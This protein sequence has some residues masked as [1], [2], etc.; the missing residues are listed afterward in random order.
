MAVQVS[1]PG[2]YIE[3]FGPAAPIEG[4]STS[5]A[6][7][8]GVAEK[9]PRN[10]A[11]LIQSW[12]KF[13]EVFGGFL[14]GPEAWL[15]Q[16]AYGFF[17][18]GGT[19]AY[20]VRVSDAE[21]SAADL[22]DRDTGVALTAI[23]VA[24]GPA[25]DTVTV[26]VTDSSRVD[27]AL[28]KVGGLPIA[29]VKNARKT[30]MVA[31]SAPFEAGSF[32]TVVKGAERVTRRVASVA[33]DSVVLTTALPST[34]DFTNGLITGALVVASAAPAAITTMTSRTVLAMSDA[35]HGLSPGDS[36]IA[37]VGT[38]ESPGTIQ[39][40]SGAT[41]TLAGAL[42]GTDDYTG[43]TLRLADLPLGA[44]RLRVV[45]PATVA[46][47]QVV[48]PGTL[49][50]IT[51]GA[52]T[53]YV[54]V[55]SS[56]GDIIALDA[57]GLTSTYGLT[58]PETP[59]VL[60]SAE[61]DLVVFDGSAGAS[62]TY[63]RL[64]VDS[65]HPTYWGTVVD[66]SVV[67][68][69]NPEEAAPADSRPAPGTYPLVG[70]VA[71]DRAA[72]WQK[73]LNSPSTYLDPLGARQDISLVV[74]PGATDPNLQS[75]LVGHCESLYDR[76]ALLDSL[77]AASIETVTDQFATV[78]S[79]KG[80]AALYY[81]WI[82]VRNP[83][84][85]VAEL[86]P[87]AGHIA[88]IY[89]RTDQTR[90]V[91]KAPANTN[92]RGSLGVESLLSNA[93]QGPINLLGINALRI[94][95]GQAQPVVW[96]A[97]TTAGDLD[98]NWQYVNIRRLFVFLEQSIERGIRGSVFEPNDL[99]LWQRL[100]R[101]ITNFLTQVWKDGALFGAK[102]EEAFYVRIDEV[103]NPPSTRSLGRLYIE[104]GVVP[105]Y[106]AEFIVLRIGIW[107]GGAEVSES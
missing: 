17:L 6:A 40:V 56:G 60:T 61:F 94:F 82:Q 64:G 103:L 30:L 93:E 48:P 36:V 5:T 85:G 59:P 15:A 96:G 89:A 106:P 83:A 80:F 79:S 91:H 81:P 52:T 8:L 78:R 24:E 62:T 57:P 101:T 100:K 42:I 90:G 22:P 65:R 37:K 66:S 43:G 99:Q 95:P 98:R 72:S 11:T 4:V 92:I 13:Q 68:L 31:T 73:L 74:V 16:G 10:T 39:G 2:V 44:R 50:A 9:G 75:A 84:T 33:A 19:T 58:D 3:E 71:D 51:A 18:N 47:N 26:T 102:P 53:E 34:P 105:T 107:D 69:T 45:S 63:P 87:P 25:G 54:R 46:L 49:L 20:V 28:A 104:V 41:I 14:S 27:D 38:K 67:R 77:P 1:Y 88:G 23:A 76:F 55:A 7:F 86:W 35:N 97:R 32:V 70:G 21:E 12:D 29:E